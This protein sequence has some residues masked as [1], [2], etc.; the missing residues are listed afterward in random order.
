VHVTNAVIDGAEI[1]N[2]KTITV[3]Y[4]NIDEVNEYIC[5]CAGVFDV[6]IFEAVSDKGEALCKYLLDFRGL[7]K[8]HGIKLPEESLL[9]YGVST[10][11]LLADA[12]L[13]ANENYCGGN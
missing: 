6:P 9:N 13:S 12:I 2:R 3:S 1:E 8:E 5:S 7:E 11:N 4:K 10:I